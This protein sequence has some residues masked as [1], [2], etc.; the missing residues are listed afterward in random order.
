[1]PAFKRL[2][3]DDLRT[4][5]R[6]E[7]LDR[8]EREGEYWDRK[9]KRGFAEADREAYAEY[10]RLLNLALPPGG[11]VQHALKYVKGQGDDGYWDTSP[12]TSPDG[13]RS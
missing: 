11:G 6:S 1:M 10:S 7:L 5:T 4:L 9:V 12:L 8:F 13:G 2:T 3:E